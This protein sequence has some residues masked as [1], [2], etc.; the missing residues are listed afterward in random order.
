M[1]RLQPRTALATALLLIAGALF[2]AGWEVTRDLRRFLSVAE[3]ATGRVAAHEPFD[4]ETRVPRERYRMVVSFETA[5]GTRVRFRSV[6]HYGRP[7][8]AVG[9]E[10]PVLYDPGSPV[11]AR[12]DRRI[13]VVAPLLVWGVAV[14]IVG[15]LG[16]GVL[17]YGPRA[18]PA[19]GRPA[20]TE[21][22]ARR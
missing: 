13:E 19:G 4:P 12:I 18:T 17:R 15:G 1:S 3:R 2:A 8:Y 7:P 9:E 22:Q 20:R 10:V 16:L 6:P 5:L 11:E 14:A 21:R